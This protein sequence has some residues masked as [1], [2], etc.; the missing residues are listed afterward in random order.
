[1]KLTPLKVALWAVVSLSALIIVLGVLFY[2]NALIA[3]GAWSNS[4]KMS[5]FLKIDVDSTQ[6]NELLK[7]I[8]GFAD[9][10]DARIVDRNEAGRSFEKTVKEYA[11]GLI[12]NDEMLDLIPESVEVEL[13]AKLSLSERSRRFGEIAQT[14]KDDTAIDDVSYS[15][16]WLEKFERINNFLKSAGL[17]AFSVLLISMSSLSSLMARVFIDDSKPEIEVYTMLGATRWSVY[18]MFLK[19]IVIFQVLS[20]ATAFAG[21]YVV[22]I[23]LLRSI[24]TYQISKL[25][26]ANFQFLNSSDVALL[27]AVIL[28]AMS[29]LSFF[30]VTA[31]INRINQI[32]N[33]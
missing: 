3:L 1:M 11:A 30:T 21:A 32:S 18:L 28:V 19:D 5:I 22:F 10:S 15:S 16:T 2:K 13:D 8:K 20:I 4:N 24:S 17:F 27:A 29:V 9:V 25:V 12:T 31:S 6:K 26:S 23:L 7:K 14:L 33:D